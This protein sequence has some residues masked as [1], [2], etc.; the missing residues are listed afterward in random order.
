MMKIPNEYIGRKKNMDFNQIMN[1]L[2]L[3]LLGDMP[4]YVFLI[5]AIV[6]I[7]FVKKAIKKVMGIVFGLISIV[8]LIHWVFVLYNTHS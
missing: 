6:V 3:Q 8:K 4:W 7:W 5:I 2:P 1:A